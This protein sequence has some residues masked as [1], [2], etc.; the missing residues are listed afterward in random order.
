[1]NSVGRAWRSALVKTSWQ[2]GA[3]CFPIPAEVR[4]LR[5]PPSIFASTAVP[6]VIL[7]TNSVNA[8]QRVSF[9]RAWAE[10]LHRPSR[11]AQAFACQF[12]GA[13]EMGADI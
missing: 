5:R 8:P 11:L 4:A 9:Q 3:D 13:F 2:C 7:A 12:A 6:E 1:M 10:R